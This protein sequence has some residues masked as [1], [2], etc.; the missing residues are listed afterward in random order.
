MHF[1][2]AAADGLEFFTRNF[3]GQK[4]PSEQ[5]SSEFVLVGNLKF[6]RAESVM[7]K[8]HSLPF[9]YTSRRPPEAGDRVLGCIKAAGR[10]VWLASAQLGS[11]AGGSAWPGLAWLGVAWPGLAWLDLTWLGLA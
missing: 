5:C 3:V 10:S 9:N 6:G 11:A 2:G 8:N 4:F 1:W 7:F